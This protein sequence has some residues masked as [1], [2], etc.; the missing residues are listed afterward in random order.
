MQNG[1][2]GLSRDL[3]VGIGLT[4]AYFA[5][6]LVGLQW[7][8]IGGAGSPVWPAAGVGLAGLLL[9]GVRLWPAI[10]IGRF[11]AGIAVGSEHP[12]AVEAAI[13][14]G[15]ALGTVLPILV[16]RRT[17]RF[18]RRLVGV[19]D[20]LALAAASAANAAVS[21]CVGVFA[22]W[23]SAGFGAGTAVIVAVNWW[24]G[25]AVGGL[26]VG[27]LIL[28]FVGAGG[29]PLSVADR[30]HLA[31][32]LVVAALASWLIFLAPGRTFF[33]I[34]SVF[35]ILIWAALAFHVRGAA[36][37]L[38]IVTAVAT[39]GAT[40]GLGPFELALTALGGRVFLA[41]QFAAVTSLTVLVLA[42]AA[43]ERRGIEALRRSEARLVDVLESTTDSVYV[44]D[45]DWRF[46]FLN[47]RAKAEISAGRDLVGARLWDA[48][49][50]ADDGPLGENYRAAVASGRPRS[51]EFYYKPLSSWF[52][53]N[54]YPS[55][56]GLTVF[57]R[58]INE[59]KAA[60]EA[61][62]ESEARLRAVLEQMPVGIAVAT[63]PEGAVVF[64]NTRAFDL[65]GHSL[66]GPRT[67]EAYGAL[68][69]LTP[70]GRPLPPEQYPLARVALHGERVERAR[71]PY[72][73]AD[74][75]VI[76]LEV[77]ASAVQDTRGK[78]VLAVAAFDDV[79]ERV[80]AE[81]TLA[82]LNADLERLVEEG[83]AKIVQMQKIES[84]GRLTGGIA[85]DFNNLLMVV[86]SAL[87]ML[88]KRIPPE[89]ARAQRLIDNATEGARRGT[90]LTQRMLAFAR[91][92]ELV[93]RPTS[94]PDLVSGM[95]ELLRRTLGPRIAVETRFAAPLS[96]AL[97]D[98]NQLELALLNLAVNARDAMPDGGRLTIGVDEVVHDAGAAIRS[99]TAMGR[100]LRIRV[101]DTGTGMDAATLARATEPFFTTKDVGRGTGMG[102]SMVQGLALQ[103]AGAFTLTSA[104]GEGTTAEILLPATDLQEDAAEEPA[105][106]P[107]PAAARPLRVLAVDDDALVLMG[108][109]GILEDLG[110]EP[111]EAGSGRAA[112]EILRAGRTVDLVIT[113]QMMPGMTGLELAEAIRAELPGLPVVLATGYSE[114]PEG[115]AAR[116]AGL[117]AKPFTQE[118]LAAAIAK[119]TAA[120]ASPAA[121]PAAPTP[122]DA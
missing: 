78:P 106:A 102:L 32:L 48:F 84:L 113:D 45:R 41:Q 8:A 17:T 114:L 1:S 33:G 112:L 98:A 119:A 4:I 26:V 93:P 92:Q 27:S 18:D 58:S 24:S 46:T 54:A 22:L 19:R 99:G 56:Q 2:S 62:A 104:P 20:V 118:Q 88:R 109:A 50:G 37:A 6:A 105:V 66:V 101:V 67:I 65:L 55:A 69:A 82:R 97:V 89:D 52:R 14:L 15:N 111:I 42:A 108:T 3:V 9:H 80:R 30:L 94:L 71:V 120:A 39:I 76:E 64:S 11:L 74:G 13:A 12:L 116:L 107:P 43:D 53:V 31:A 90:A 117:L 75:V 34:W 68:G 110:H 121:T 70:D 51:F 103:S 16:L 59:E 36:A 57:F 29:R 5:T 115:A 35:P 83:A 47:A 87:D 85:H 25:N 61:L 96:R 91:R 81:E 7:A 95:T 86:L 79:T 63:L 77:S 100:Y 72:K 40:I 38:A 21:A 60:A 49:P 44:L 122:A 10:A 23:L 73:R 28:A